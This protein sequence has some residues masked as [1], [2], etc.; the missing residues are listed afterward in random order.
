VELEDGTPLSESFIVD[1]ASG[2]SGVYTAKDLGIKMQGG[3]A[4]HP[5]VEEEIGAGFEGTNK[6]TNKYKKD[7]PGEAVEAFARMMR[8][9]RKANTPC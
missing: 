6:L 1:R 3:F 5:S 2:Y 9:K 4:L 8:A 7:T